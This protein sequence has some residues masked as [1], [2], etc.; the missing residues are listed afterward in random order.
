MITYLVDVLVY[1]SEWLMRG[2]VRLTWFE[3]HSSNQSLRFHVRL[4]HAFQTV[5]LP[6]RMLTIEAFPVAARSRIHTTTMTYS[7]G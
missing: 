4:T 6:R 3:K 7:P 2:V 1:T 5:R